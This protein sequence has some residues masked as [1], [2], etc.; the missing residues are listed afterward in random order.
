MNDTPQLPGA[1]VAKVLRGV[2]RP[3]VNNPIDL[4]EQ[5][6]NRKDA[7]EKVQAL[8]RQER[9][10]AEQQANQKV[11]KGEVVRMM[12]QLTQHFD[13]QFKQ[14]AIEVSQLVIT[15]N[16]N[17]K[18]FEQ[19]ILSSSNLGHILVEALIANGALTLADLEA[20]KDKLMEEEKARIA[21]EQAQKEQ[22]TKVEE[23]VNNGERNQQQTDSSANES[24]GP[25]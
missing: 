5:I 15:A 8:S 19:R 9:N 23:D 20:A 6:K 7:N 13:G 25:Q 2:P 17:F 22:Q 21:Q 12:N 11:S 18:T 14:L 4:E 16:G 24:I 3:P 1:D 10:R